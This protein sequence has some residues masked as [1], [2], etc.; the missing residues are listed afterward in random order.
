MNDMQAQTAQ[1]DGRFVN[2]PCNGNET[3]AQLAVRARE[4]R[5]AMLRMTHRAGAGHVGG[6]LSEM[7]ILTALYFGVMNVD[8]ER[9]GWEDRDRFLL[10][11]GHAS[12]GFYTVLAHRG[13]FPIDWLNTFDEADSRLQGHPDMHKCPGADYSTGSLGQGLSVG[14]GFALAGKALGK[15]YKTF[16]L[17][18]DGEAQEGQVWEALMYAAAHKV[19]NLVAVFDTNGVQL[20]GSSEALTGADKL[21]SML[22]G[23]GWPVLACDGHDMPALAAALAEARAQSGAGPVAVLARTVKG[24]GVSFMEGRWQWHGKAPNAE[25]LALALAELEGGAPNAQA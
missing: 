14:I 17:M 6:S 13:Y 7:D 8:P 10:S 3:P 20:A 22:R 11:K 21:E 19:E 9:P 2:R 16:V 15:S 23:F 1:G 4:M 12:P 25:E 18:G 24:K 5:A